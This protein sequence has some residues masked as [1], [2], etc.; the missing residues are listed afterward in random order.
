VHFLVFL[1]HPKPSSDDYGSVDGAYVSCWV[2]EP[3]ASAAELVARQ[4][5][6]DAGWDIQELDEAHPISENHY[7]ASDPGREKADQARIDGIVVTFHVWDVGAP[8][9]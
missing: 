2:N 5:I 8:D 1:A 9:E 3:V 6:D 7:S 4:F